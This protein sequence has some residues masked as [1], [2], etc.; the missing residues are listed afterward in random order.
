MKKITLTLAAAATLM[1]AACNNSSYTAE[2]GEAKQEAVAAGK[3]YTAD[4]AASFV[5]WKCAHKGGFAPRYGI[6]KLTEG[7]VSVENGAITGGRFT[8]DI[9]SLHVDSASVTEKGKKATDLEGHLKSPDFFDAAKYPTAK[10]VVTAV[11]PFDAATD[12]SE[13]PGTTSVVSGNLTIKDSTVN[14]TFPAVV[15]VSDAGVGVKA[16]FS[17]ERTAWGL[18]YGTEGDPKD[19][20][21]S[22]NIELTIDFKAVPK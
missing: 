19:W 18:K 21:I 14:V 4:V 11:K 15:T 17:V 5:G 3:E 6:L 16:K 2:T 1:F 20:G 8:V 7:S 13:L 9:N 22:N 12:K 10:F